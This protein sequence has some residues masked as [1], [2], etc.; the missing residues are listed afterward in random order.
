MSANFGI[1][2][3]TE[4]TD[5]LE[6]GLGADVMYTD[7]FDTAADADPVLEQEAYTK[8]NA[9]IALS[10]ID[11]TWSVALL[12]KNLT[13]KT[14]SAWGNDIPLGSF[15]FDNSYFQVIDAPRSY[16]IQATYNF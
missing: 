3:N 5:S 9:R 2:Y 12:G 8:V 15:G 16:E 1:T 4:I 13:D 11:G 10:D 7:D 14:T 6:L